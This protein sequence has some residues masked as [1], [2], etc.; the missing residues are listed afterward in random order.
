MLIDE[1]VLELEDELDIFMNPKKKD[2]LNLPKRKIQSNSFSFSKAVA[3]SKLIKPN[4]VNF[5]YNLYTIGH[6]D[7]FVLAA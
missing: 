5:S 7:L 1:L 6:N 4:G 3:L 2:L